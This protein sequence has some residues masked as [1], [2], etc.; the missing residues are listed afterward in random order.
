M[1]DLYDELFSSL[2][3]AV[4]QSQEKAGNKHPRH[5]AGVDVEQQA[6]V[7]LQEAY[8]GTSRWLTV[9]LPNG[10]SGLVQLFIPPGVDTGTKVRFAGYGNP[11]KLGEQPGDLYLVITIRPCARFQRRGT[12]LYHEYSSNLA[13]LAL[14]TTVQISTLDEKLLDLTIPAGTKPGEQ[15]R[16]AGKGMPRVDQPDQRGDLYV[17]VAAAVPEPSEPWSKPRTPGQ[18]RAA[19][20]REATR[21]TARKPD[22]SEKVRSSDWTTDEIIWVV[23]FA[24]F[25]IIVGVGAGF[26]L[27]WFTL[28]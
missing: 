19:S 13:E 1:A 7:T 18:Q 5:C 16:L 6:E 17:T 27:F 26:L 28:G 8:Q 12:D 4:R 25:F 21:E 23:I 10:Q 3:D 15:F 9:T 20:H 24:V 2:Q 22:A 14:G 11:G